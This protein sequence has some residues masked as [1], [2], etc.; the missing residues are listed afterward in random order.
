MSGHRRSQGVDQFLEDTNP[1]SVPHR[2]QA[3][4]DHLAIGTLVFGDPLGDML[5]KR[6]EF[7]GSGWPRCVDHCLWVLEIFAHCGARD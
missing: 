4:E 1:S 6:I 2:S 3:A 7:G 5:L